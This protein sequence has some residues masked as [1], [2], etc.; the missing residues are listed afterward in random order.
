MWERK[1]S[2]TVYSVPEAVGRIVNAQDREV[3]FSLERS[4]NRGKLLA[5]ILQLPEFQSELEVA[6]EEILAGV[7]PDANEATIEGLFERVLYAALRDFGV[8]FNPEKEVSPDSRRHFKRGRVD[9]RLGAVLIEY[10]RP[11]K[12]SR[13]SAGD[14]N[15]AVSQLCDYLRTLR[16]TTGA[17]CYGFLTDGLEFMEV[18]QV[19]DVVH[20]LAPLE[21]LDGRG[22]LALVQN[23]VSLGQTALTPENLIRDFCG[24]PDSGVLYEVSRALYEVLG[25]SATEKTLML[26]S[27]WEELFRLSHDDKSQQRRI[28]ERRIDLADLFAG[29]ID[30]AAEEYRAIF[31]LHTAYA[32]IVKLMAYRV[33]SELRFGETLSDYYS[34]LR[35]HPAGLRGRFARLEDGEVFRDLGILNLLEG[36]FFSWYCD[37]GQWGRGIATAVRRLLLVLCKY[38]KTTAV[39]SQSNAVDLFRKLYEAA[40]PQ[41]VRASF[42][43]FYTPLWVAQHAF[44]NVEKPPGWRMLDPCCGSGT[45]L[46]AAVQAIR[47]EA[48]H[49]DVLAETCSRVAGIDLNPLAVLTARVNFFLH[50]CDLLPEEVHDLVIPVYLGDASY[51]PERH[52]IGGVDCLE[53]TL[54]TLRDP[55]EVALPLVLLADPASFF[56]LMREFEAKVQAQEAE[57]AADVLLTPLGGVACPKPVAERIEVLSERLVELEA[58]GWNGVWARILANYLCT[59]ALGQFDVVVGNPPW[60]DWKNLPG[61]YRE[62]IKSLC[63]DRGLFS[64][65]RRTGGINLNVCALI[66][67]VAMENWL[68]RDG[69]LAF[70]MPK[71]MTVQP[72]FRGWRRLPGEVD[73]HFER[74][75]DW[76]HAGNP[77][78]D[79]RGGPQEDFMTYVVGPRWPRGGIVPVNTYTKHAGDRT[80]ASR[81]ETLEEALEHLAIVNGWAGQI[82]PE[83]TMFTFARTKS[84]LR[85][86][87]SVPGECAYVAREG[88]EFYPQELLLFTYDGPGPAPGTAFLRNCQN[89]RSK[90]RI[91][92]ARTPLETKFIF[93]LVKGPQIKPFSHEYGDLLVPFPY[94]EDDARRPI[95]PEELESESPWLLRYYME[96]EEL[97]RAQTD[98]S[99]RLRGANAGAFYGLARVGPYSF[100]STYV[101]FRDNTRWCACVVSVEDVPWGETKRLVFQNHAVSICERPGGGFISAREA[102]YICAI[103][104]A[105]IV[106]RYLTSSSDPRS[107]KIRP[108]I[109]LPPYSSRDSRHRRLSALS[110]KAHR[111]SAAIPDCLE[112]IDRIYLEMCAHRH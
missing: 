64:G 49:D 34:L 107:F 76:S 85:Q 12:L 52:P 16:S 44:R 66:C 21:Q 57:E 29:D 18:R 35:A 2:P 7:S 73:R 86:L 51:V 111:D 88:I 97:I 104:N 96:N 100:A 80:R 38:E 10:K 62:K 92:S 56:E 98:Y 42:G 102:H 43:E 13:G 3:V 58:E 74:F 67:H 24:H 70:L 89:P 33:L 48:G 39:Y 9:A 82:T 36:D 8:R 55:I 22:L 40:V 47:Q 37:Q 11:E 91:R 77:F 75:D 90:Y 28:E 108:P 5:A 63:I 101:A 72:S 46:I 30:S 4:R 83:D 94:R 45:F 87:A 68:A 27:E 17:D 95:P 14:V 69:R 105:P 93:P 19:D 71:E 106:L 6:A 112:E 110:A 26:M 31:A 53:Y 81:W 60:V 79:E 103:L 99:D 23:V 78:C 1:D 61:G 54:R 25:Q 15:E 50:V 84:E 65:D 59:G 41:S 109:Y 32:I 20:S